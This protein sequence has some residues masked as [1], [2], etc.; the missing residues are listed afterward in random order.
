MA[1][2]TTEM[3]DKIL[4]NQKCINLT[5]Y[6]KNG[7][8]VSTPIWFARENNDIYI[9][10]D[11]KTW[12]AKRMKN[13]PKV[14]FVSCSYMGKVRRKFS[15]LRIHGDAEFLEGEEHNKAEQRIAKKYKFLYLFTKRENNIFLR[16][17]P[18][19]ILREPKPE[20]EEDC[21]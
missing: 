15:D 7:E 21:E 19:A 4:N 1:S 18:T 16:I 11:E 9:M 14:V 12:K 13:N 10:T 17:T 2:K 8:G 20:E 5:T 6:K 3:L